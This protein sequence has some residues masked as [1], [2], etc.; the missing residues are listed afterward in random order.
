MKHW[1]AKELPIDQ[2]YRIFINKKLQS[3]VN[4]TNFLMN[5]KVMESNKISS[6][7]LEVVVV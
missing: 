6:E 4:S 2:T 7:R 1:L 3:S 5:G